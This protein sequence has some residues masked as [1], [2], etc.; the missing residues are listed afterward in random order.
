[1]NLS[2]CK[3]V[4]LFN[5]VKNKDGEE[6]AIEFRHYGVSSRQR[7]VNKVIKRV[8]NSKK[9][10]NLSRYND[11]SDYLLHQQGGGFTSESEADDLP[12]SKL[13]LPEDF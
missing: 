11:I 5:L 12:D 13:V 9:I 3:R 8:V 1:M 2:K 10:P 4:V 6:E 7:D